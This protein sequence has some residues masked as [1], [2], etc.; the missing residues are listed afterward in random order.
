M[1]NG[2]PTETVVHGSTGFLCEPNPEDFSSAMGTF[3]E[4]GEPLMTKMGEDG[5]KRVSKFFSFKACADQ[6]DKLVQEQQ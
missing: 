3:V 6:L 1:N 4:S 5:R 2:G